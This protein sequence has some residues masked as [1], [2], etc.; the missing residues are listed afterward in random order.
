M[1][2]YTSR[3]RSSIPG[4]PCIPQCL[5]DGAQEEVWASKET[6]EFGLGR[7]AGPKGARSHL[8]SPRLRRSKVELRRRKDLPRTASAGDQ[9]CCALAGR[10]TIRFEGFCVIFMELR[11]RQQVA[12]SVVSF[13]STRGEVNLQG[14]RMSGPLVRATKT[15]FDGHQGCKGCILKK[16]RR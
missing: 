5:Y 7:T 13:P 15:F 3:M 11:R 6:M 8:R 12:V 2:M 1:D 16:F 4:C 9:G 14:E 10:T